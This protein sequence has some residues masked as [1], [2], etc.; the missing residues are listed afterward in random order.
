[1]MVHGGTSWLLHAAGAAQVQVQ[2][3]NVKKLAAGLP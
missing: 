2:P 1:M 3:F